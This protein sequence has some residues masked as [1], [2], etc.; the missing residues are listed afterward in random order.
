VPGVKTPVAGL[1][2]VRSVNIYPERVN[3]TFQT[4][5]SGRPASGSTPSSCQDSRFSA[6]RVITNGYCII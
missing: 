2:A 5:P 6:F 4:A 1:P 3:L